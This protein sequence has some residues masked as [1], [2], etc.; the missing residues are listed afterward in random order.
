MQSHKLLNMILRY[1]PFASAF[2]QFAIPQLRTGGPG[3]RLDWRKTTSP[4]MAPG[5]Y[6]IRPP[7]FR[8]NYTSGG[9]K[10]GGAIP[11]VVDQNREG[12]SPDHRSE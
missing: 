7:S 3:S 6:K 12:M 4:L 11:S 1:F 5:A 2:A 10:A 9:T 8:T